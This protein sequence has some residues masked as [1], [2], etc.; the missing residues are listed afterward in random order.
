MHPGYIEFTS[1]LLSLKASVNI[2]V[3]D[4]SP[5][6]QTLFSA[7][8]SH[9]VK[10]NISLN[11]F[12]FFTFSMEASYI[13]ECCPEAL[14]VQLLLPCVNGEGPQREWSVR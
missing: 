4:P 8:A 7:S 14:V 11:D 3:K 9:W 2:K 5:T 12:F 13:N 6:V 1:S 10:K